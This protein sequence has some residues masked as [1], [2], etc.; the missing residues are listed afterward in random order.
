MNWG[1]GIVIA[2]ALFMSF[3]VFLVVNI[4]AQKV[5]LESEDYYKKEINYE[6]EIT[7]QNN[8][9]ALPEKIQLLSQEE[10]VVVQIPSE[11]TFTNIEVQFLRPDN[12]KSDKA[13][14]VKGTKSYLIPKTQF[15]KGQYKVE[16]RYSVNSKNCLQKESITI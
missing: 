8:A 14:S 13:F 12:K 2:M 10:F 3:I 11:G 16:L 7:E 5:D 9:N 15:T 6:Q 4:M 1:K